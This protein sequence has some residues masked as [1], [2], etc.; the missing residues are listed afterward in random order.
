[1]LDLR[2][3]HPGLAPELVARI[4]VSMSRRNA[5]VLRNA[6]PATGL[7]AKFSIQ[8]AMACAL[9]AGRVGLQELTD[10]FVQQPHIQGVFERVHLEF[11][12]REDPATGYA[13]YDQVTL[14][15]LDGRTLRSEQVVLA[16]GASG[17]PLAGHEV[18]AKFMDC[19]RGALEPEAAAALYER[20]CRLETIARLDLH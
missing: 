8:F 3:A 11:D 7:E 17:A 12:P 5:R 14:E 9:S 13:P 16:R 2:R 15:L 1:M 19:A 18:R 20:L 10:G 4:T 6:R